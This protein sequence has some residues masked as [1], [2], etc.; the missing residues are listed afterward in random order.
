MICKYLILLMK[1]KLYVFIA[2]LRVGVPPWRAI[3]HDASKF[4]SAE[5]MQYARWSFGGRKNSDEFA[6][7][8]LHHQNHNPHHWEYWISRSN[9][10]FGPSLDKNH[11]LVM[12]ETYTREMVAD[13]MGA[14]KAYTGSWDMTE[15]LLKNLADIKLHPESRKL[16]NMVLG[17]Q[18]Y[19]YR[20]MAEAEP[21]IRMAGDELESL[22]KALSESAR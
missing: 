19:M 4:S 5:F 3:I 7:A 15:W 13:W 21:T 22:L 2:C 8:W 17:E 14:S 6:A 1:H 10:K 9:H 20:V 18:G 11:C 16:V 12:P